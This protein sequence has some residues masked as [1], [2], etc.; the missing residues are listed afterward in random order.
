MVARSGTL[1]APGSGMKKSTRKLQTVRSVKSE[2]LAI[3]TGGTTVFGGVKIGFSVS[4][5]VWLAGAAAA[6]AQS[7]GSLL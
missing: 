6:D 3:I 4:D 1:G 2:Q 5:V 7:L